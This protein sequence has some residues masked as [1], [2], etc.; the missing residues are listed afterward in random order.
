MSRRRRIAHYAV[1]GLLAVG[2]SNGLLAVGRAPPPAIPSITPVPTTA[3][4][5][6]YGSDD[7]DV[8]N[9][10]AFGYVQEE[11][12]ISGTV[13]GLPYTTRVLVRRPADPS[14]FSGIVLAESIRSTAIRTMWGLR[15][16]FD[17][18]RPRLCGAGFQS[19]RHPQP[20]QTVEP[21]PLCGAQHAGRGSGYAGLWPRAGE[22]W[23]RAG[24][25]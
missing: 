8:A 7:P 25:Y 12:F 15:D 22:S 23:P 19:P 18:A 17:A 5:V 6:P 21:E 13:D 9:L 16:Y 3:D 4:S 10:A 20:R 24:C 2:L 1:T 14:R 11:F